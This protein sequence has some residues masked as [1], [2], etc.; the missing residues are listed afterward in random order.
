MVLY[1]VSSSYF[2]GKACP[3]AKYGYNRDGK[4]GKLQIVFGLL[5]NKEG[6]PISIEVFEG[7]TSDLTT[8]TQQIEKVRARFRIKQVIWVG[9]RVIICSTRI[10]SS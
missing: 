9:D 2:E 3:I 8:F 6:C 5:C 10:K 4:K 7:N 1:N